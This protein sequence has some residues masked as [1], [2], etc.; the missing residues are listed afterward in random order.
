MDDLPLKYRSF[1]EHWSHGQEVASKRVDL[2]VRQDSIVAAFVKPPLGD[3]HG[4]PNT[5]IGC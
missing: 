1:W 4:S 2:G 3:S 5:V